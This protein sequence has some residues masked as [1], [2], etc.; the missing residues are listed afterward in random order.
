MKT[1]D[2]RSDTVTLPTSEMMDAINSATL[3][4]DVY[5]EDS[6]TIE[7]ENL[8]ATITGKEAGLLVSS[9]TMGNLISCLV[10]AP[11]GTEA[12]MGHKSHIFIY[13]SGGISAYGGIHS[14]QLKNDDNG[15]IDINMIKDAI[16]IDDV[17]FPVT[18]LICLENT[19]NKCYGFPLELDYIN[20]VCDI[21]HEN[22]I[23]VHMDGARLFNACVVLGESADKITE[24]VDS[25]T[26][27]LSK[28]L[29]SPIGSV[30]CGSTNFI[31]EARR[32]RKSLGGGMRQT[33]IIAAA[34]IVSLNQMR[35]R[36]KDDHANAKYLAN[37][38]HKL[39]GIELN[40]NYVPTNIIFFNF[41]HPD[42][43]SSDLVNHMKSHGIIFSDYNGKHCRLVLHHGISR[44][45][46]E[47]VIDVFNKLLS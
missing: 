43:S 20:S 31:A 17:H 47:K 1:I 45:D 46:V 44:D 22:K 41:N 5:V 16:R 36:L 14:H 38:L 24:N 11:R 40:I 19:H 3:G 4:D 30:I 28:G 2:L 39:P 42:M 12:I 9:G 33:G 34:G 32:I 15:T 7:L 23:K 25:V 18:S 26:F 35:N 27:C 10:H 8:A 21:A 13:E 37:G 6:S 29:A